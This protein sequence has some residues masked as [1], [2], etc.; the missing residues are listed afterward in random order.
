MYLYTKIEIL[1]ILFSVFKT[2]FFIHTIVYEYIIYQ[3]IIMLNIL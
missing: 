3:L 2:R 1:L